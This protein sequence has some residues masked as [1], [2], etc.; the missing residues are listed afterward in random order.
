MQE[1]SGEQRTAR[2]YASELF[3]SM[4]FS[5]TWSVGKWPLS[6]ILRGLRLW[7][8]LTQCVCAKIIISVMPQLRGSISHFPK[9]Q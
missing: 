8:I 7:V 9:L 6:V 1:V 4:I 3:C 2:K 5:M